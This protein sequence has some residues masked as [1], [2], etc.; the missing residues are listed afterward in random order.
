MNPT[1]PA[2]PPVRVSTPAGVLATIPHLLGFTPRDSLVVLGH[3]REAGR[4]QAVLRYDLPDPPSAGLAAQI[5]G[6]AAA[7]LARQPVTGA[8]AIGYGPGHLVT[9]LADAVRD[10]IPAAGLRLRDVLRVEDGRF[11]SYLCQNPACCPPG[12]VAFDATTHPAGV[13]LTAAGLTALAS[14]EALAAT[15][16]PVTGPQATEMG[17]A[18]E[19]AERAARALTALRGHAEVE[20]RALRLV[21]AAIGAYRSG[22][23]IVSAHRHAW[24]TLVLT[25]LRVR[26]DAWARMDPAHHEQHRRLWADVVRRAQPGYVAA[27]ACLLAV[28]AWQGGDGALANLALDRALAEDPGYSMAQLLRDALAAGTPPAMAA[29]PMTPDEVAAS[30]TGPATPAGPASPPAS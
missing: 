14:R 10:A 11:W 4:V 30:Y 15:I 9:P 8:V 12:G 3:T 29:P 26:D 7:A 5:A 16:A 6:H 17:K 2:R 19:I 21:A 22:Q 25:Q 28:A 20:R 13:A 18:T 24:L 27:P 23:A 1:T